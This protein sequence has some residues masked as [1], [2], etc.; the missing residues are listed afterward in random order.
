MKWSTGAAAYVPCCH[1][2]SPCSTCSQLLHQPSRASLRH[3]LLSVPFRAVTL[4][5]LE[6]RQ[7]ER[8]LVASRQVCREGRVASER[9]DRKGV[10]TRGWRA[11][12]MM[13]HGCVGRNEVKR[14]VLC[15]HLFIFVLLEIMPTC[16]LPEQEVQE[17]KVF[18]NELQRVLD[19]TKET[20]TSVVS[21]TGR[22]CH[23]GEAFCY[24]ACWS[25][26]LDRTKKY[27]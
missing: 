6:I 20:G 19:K 13:L 25:V 2:H 18:A 1:A 11:A 22:Q 23:R 8:L 3:W 7:W 21:C 15:L 9:K 26:V 12:W 4:Q 16:A 5:I 27:V 14:Q 24:G 17:E 10:G